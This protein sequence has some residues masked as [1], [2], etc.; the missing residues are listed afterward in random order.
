MT[1]DEMRII[2][3]EAVTVAVK[4]AFREQACPLSAEDRQ[5]VPHLYGFI[6]DIGDGDLG[7]GVRNIRQHYLSCQGLKFIEH[8]DVKKNMEFVTEI[9][10]KKVWITG[11]AVTMACLW[12]LA[13]IGEIF[14]TGLKDIWK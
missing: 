13:K 10:K 2:V 5:V 14:L 1:P 9:R 12:I 3:A 7:K 11:A 8:P 4:Q 6:K